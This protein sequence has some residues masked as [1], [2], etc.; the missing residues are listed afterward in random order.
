M[1]STLII[2]LSDPD[3]STVAVS[4]GVLDTQI[5]SIYIVCLYK[6]LFVRLLGKLCQGSLFRFPRRFFLLI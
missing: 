6:V 5:L 2:L 1:I 3:S 4:V